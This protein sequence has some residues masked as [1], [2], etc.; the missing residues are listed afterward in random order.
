MDAGH[1]LVE[2][3]ADVGIRGW[4]PDL[5]GLFVRMARGL[6]EVIV[7]PATVSARE[8]REVRLPAAQTE[9]LLHDWLDELNALHQSK[10]E[11]YG[12]FEVELSGGSLSARVR[13]EPIDLDRH[14]LRVEVKA[15]TWHDLR[16][17]RT[18]RGFE[19]YVLLDI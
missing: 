10:G 13:G 14:E 19:A 9:D 8:E 18:E 3:T 1:E 17:T 4:A 11:V 2:H 5:P 15:V 12:E 6:F 7:D 16:V